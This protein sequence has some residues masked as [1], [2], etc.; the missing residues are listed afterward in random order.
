MSRPLPPLPVKLV[1]GLFTADKGLIQPVAESLVAHFGRTDMVSSWFAFDDTDYYAPEMGGPL[2]RRILAFER[3]I[4]PGRLADIKRITN[5]VE[6]RWT[7]AGSRRVNI[8][9]GLLNRARFVL[10]TGK[11]YAH[12]I[13]LE[14]GIYAD[15][16]LIFTRGAF[17]ILPW[18]YPDYGRPP[19]RDFLAKVRR[20]YLN[21]IN[22]TR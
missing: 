19:V 20:R 6:M 11:D 16:T 22:R 8:D 4:D 3:L 12:R 14:Q 21:R 5:A 17:Q 7:D 13:Y 1:I 10:A 15:L 2:V 9:P 18:T